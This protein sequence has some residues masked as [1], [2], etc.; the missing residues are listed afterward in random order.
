MSIKFLVSGREGYFGFW[1]GGGK[2]RFYFYGRGD[3]SETQKAR[4]SQ[5]RIWAFR[6]KLLRT[7]PF[8]L[9]KPGF[10][11]GV[12]QGQSS[13]RNSCFTKKSCFGPPLD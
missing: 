4:A 8:A 6:E 13:I 12:P 5:V 10:I 9:K 11:M 7:N 3:F 2:C 1:G